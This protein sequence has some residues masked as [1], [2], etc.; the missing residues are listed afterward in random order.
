VTGTQ[1]VRPTTACYETATFNTTTCSWDVTGTAPSPSLTSA[2]AC[3]SYTWAVNGQTYTSSGSYTSNLTCQPEILNL[4]ITPSTLNSN[5]II[6]EG[7]YTWSI[8]GET[9]T[10]SGS[11]TSVA[12]CNTEVLELLIVEP[13]A[14]S[15][16]PPS[17]SVQPVDRSICE[18]NNVD[19][20]AGADFDVNNTVKWQRSSNNG[21]SWVDIT[22]NLDGNNGYSGFTSE[23]LTV[24]GAT[25]S[26]NG[27]LYQAVFTNLNGS[28]AT[29]AVTLTVNAAPVI[30]TQPSLTARKVT[31]NLVPP[32]YSVVTQ[33]TGSL[34][35]QWYKN[36]NP[37]NT[38]GTAVSGATSASYVPSTTMVS[39]NYHYVVIT[40]ENGCAVASQVT[41]YLQV[42]GP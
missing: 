35:Y 17:I 25:A 30:I 38:G 28:N 16:P 36:G 8:N 29:N 13:P 23:T 22:A 40:N 5:S 4:T 27:Y 2:S 12:N 33:G 34:T 42:C 37:E 31:L 19:F 15:L 18:V 14:P 7:F 26:M 1:P 10:V 41:G 3:D 9:Y 32:A 6:A 21:I 20:V 11:Y 24:N 39:T